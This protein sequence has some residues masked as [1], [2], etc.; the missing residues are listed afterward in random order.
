[1]KKVKYNKATEFSNIKEIINESIK[2]YNNNNAF[3]V[4]HKQEKDIIYENITYERF[5]DEL[6][7]LGTALMNMGLKDKK[8]AVIGENSYEWMLVYLSVLNG[9]GTIIPLDKGLPEM[10]IENSLKISGCDAIFFTDKNLEMIEN[11][12]ERKQTN[13]EKFICMNNKCR[14]LKDNTNVFYIKDLVNR[15][16]E[17][18]SNGDMNFINA[19]IDC[20]KTSILV[21][22]SGTTST[23]KAVML[24]HK[25]IASNIYSLTSAEKFYSTDVNIALLPFHHTFGSTGLI[26]FLSVGMTNVFCDG[27]RHIQ[28]NLKEYKVT[29]FVGVPLIIESMY[30]KIM[31]KVEKENKTKKLKFGLKISKI[32]MKFK[33]DIRRKIFK[34]I[35][36]NL[37]GNIRF[38][39]SGASGI[40]KKV[41][42]A[43]NNF[44]IL[45]VQGYGLTETS[46]VLFAENEQYIKY[47]SVGMPMRNV[48]AKID[49]PN[50][51][52]IG[53]I[54]VKGPNVMLGYYKNEE[55]TKKILENGWFYTG[56]LGYFDKEGY[57]FIT[58]R[59]KNVI[60]MKNGKNIY[61][62]EIEQLISNLPYVSENMVFS[63]E[64]G[65][66]ILLSVKIVY[67][68]EYIKTKYSEIEEDKIKEIIWEDIKN[69]NKTLPNY[70]HIKNLVITDE[71]M[72]KTTTAKIKRYEE[73]KREKV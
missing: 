24:S 6:N 70:K 13:V 10:E 19:E 26:L 18:V 27:L 69:L 1:M 11:I 42:E 9:V 64:K 31:A 63:K 15:G 61:P 8:I 58:G 66:D 71:P 25:N 3:I 48:E 67:N 36:D 39:I 2:K 46:P 37:G 55:E 43:F 22:T 7:A 56:D 53:E 72:I 59:K 35:I 44:G 68:K 49:N 30:K 14:K 21:F 73:I 62:E 29:T 20:D 54:I 65:N 32:L 52:G 17:L 60:V 28:E 40:D 12:N 33:I 41:A 45:T 47:G 38:I 57:L 34:E 16:K 23:S 4:K 5:G 51:E 50:E